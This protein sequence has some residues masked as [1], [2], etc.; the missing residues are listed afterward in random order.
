MHALYAKKTLMEATFGMRLTLIHAERV[1][2]AKLCY[3]HLADLHWCPTHQEK[4]IFLSNSL[5]QLFTLSQGF[6][7][8]LISNLLSKILKGHL[9]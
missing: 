5:R 7:N 1:E 4:G 8:Y 3:H 9:K 2:I 6:G